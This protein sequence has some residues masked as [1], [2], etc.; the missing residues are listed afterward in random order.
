MYFFYQ[1]FISYT[2]LEKEK[3]LRR[4]IYDWDRNNDINPLKLLIQLLFMLLI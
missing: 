4:K 1:N 3:D 2:F